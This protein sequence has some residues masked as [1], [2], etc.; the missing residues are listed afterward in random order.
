MESYRQA[1]GVLPELLR[2]CALAVDKLTMGR[3]EELRLRTGRVPTLVLPEGERD[4]PNAAPVVKA[5]LE[6]LVE[7]AGRWSLHAV[8]DQIRRGFLTV[9][10]GH[11]LG[12]C[13]TV[14]LQG[15]QIQTIR[16]FSGANLRIARQVHGIGRSVAGQLFRQ[17]QLQNTL[18]LGPPGAGKT[19]LLRDLIRSISSGET[20]VPARICVADERGELAASFRGRAQMDLGPQTDVLDGCPK[21][22]AISLLIRGMNP[23]V[24]AVDEITAPEDVRAMEEAMGCGVALL[25]TAHGGG[26]EDLKRR[27]LYRDMME[28]N[29]FQ[30]VVMIRSRAGERD[31]QVVSMEELQW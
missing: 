1:V 24:I 19:T 3:T 14:V 31:M 6:H 15:V 11:R 23:Q 30:K 8:L 4:I 27:P 29:I 18:I 12:L 21:G 26:M 10:G 25:A 22:A 16:D 7:L 13:G 2:T 5:D 20:G 9:E 17:G 28:K